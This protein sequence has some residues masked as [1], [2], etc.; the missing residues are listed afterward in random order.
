MAGT[1]RV[2]LSP[3]EGG[4]HGH[5]PAD[6]PVLPQPAGHEGI[7]AAGKAAALAEAK[8]WLTNLTADEAVRRAAGLTDGV[9]RGAREKT[10][11]KLVVPGADPAVGQ[12]YTPF[13][14]PR[15]WAAFVLIGDPD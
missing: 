5:G 10:P 3:V 12:D 7:E 13:A 8:A 11:L 15:Y 6:G 2:C 4:R 14:H 9:A 1:R